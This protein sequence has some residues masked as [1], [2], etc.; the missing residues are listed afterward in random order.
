M[1]HRRIADL[2]RQI[3]QRPF[4]SMPESPSILPMSR[5]C[6]GFASRS[7]ITGKIECP[8]ARI[9]ASGSLASMFAACR[10]EFGRTYLNSYIV[11]SL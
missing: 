3:C 5:S 1:A 7:F 4:S 9:F 6:E 10:T 2:G 8:P 11:V